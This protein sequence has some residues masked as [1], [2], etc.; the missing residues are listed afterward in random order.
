MPNAPIERI[1]F[2]PAEWTVKDSDDN[3]ETVAVKAAVTDARHYISKVTASFISAPGAAKLLEIKSGT[4]VI[5]AEYVPVASPFSI[6]R[7]FDRPLEGGKSE[8]VS[9]TL[10]AS[11][12]GG[13]VSRVNM[14]GFTVSTKR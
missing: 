2:T 5:W 4:T 10:A 1:A 7:D 9:A 13:V 6:D 8:L 3:A 12:T 14:S 11:G